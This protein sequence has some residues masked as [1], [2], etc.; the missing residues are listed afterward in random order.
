MK[1]I[2]TMKFSQRNTVQILL[3][4]TFFFAAGSSS[5]ASVF[6][7]YPTDDFVR[8]T[9]LLSGDESDQVPE[10]NSFSLL[11]ASQIVTPQEHFGSGLS[12]LHFSCTD[13]LILS[14]NQSLWIDEDPEDQRRLLSRFLYPFFFF[15]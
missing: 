7:N 14:F 3:S 4:I 13:S 6:E 2:C 15:W 9:S 8:N 10:F 11:K 5:F 1:Y 12:A